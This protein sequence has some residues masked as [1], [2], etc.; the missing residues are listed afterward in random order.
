MIDL[1][2]HILPAFDDGARDLDESVEMA[3]IL[4]NDGVAHVVATPHCHHYLPSYREDILPRVRELNA[5][6]RARGVALE[7]LPGSE[8]QLRDIDNYKAN[9]EAGKFCHLGDR[10][11]YSLLEFPWRLEDAPDG[12]PELVVWLKARGTTP[13]LAH[14]ER[15]PLLR[16]NAALL[17]AL[18]ENGALIQITVDSL[19]GAHGAG[20][21]SHGEN[22]VREYSHVA[23][24]ATD[25]HGT[26]RCS[27][28]SEGFARVENLCG[29]NI[30]Q[31]IRSR[32]E[33]IGAALLAHSQS[34]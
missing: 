30:S 13:I 29:E 12:A 26:S 32:M 10:R 11:E 31:K 24:L 22:I 7:V 21:L 20:A 18:I 14:P 33:N 27:G 2:S 28:L 9:Y 6:F 25:S 15:T 1:H 17:A 19:S 23:V 16:E 5:S 8:I 34:D 4:E 3:R